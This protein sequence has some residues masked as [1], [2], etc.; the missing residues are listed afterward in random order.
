MTITS[1]YVS[2]GPAH[3]CVSLHT[4]SIPVGL[5]AFVPGQ[6]LGTPASC[7]GGSV[8]RRCREAHCG[9]S[10]LRIR[11]ANS[12][13]SPSPTGVMLREG[14]GCPTLWGVGATAQNSNSLLPCL[15]ASTPIQDKLTAL[16]IRAH[17]PMYA[18]QSS[19]PLA[20][21]VRLLH[22]SSPSR[23]TSFPAPIAV[24]VFLGP[25]SG[26]FM[27]IHPSHQR[28]VLSHTYQQ[29]RRVIA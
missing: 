2:T 13:Y 20:L 1:E 22:A 7:I 4:N 23:Q 5:R 15:P 10:T 29:V 8:C 11:L 24:R 6:R 3:V 26:R 12:H 25:A 28:S 16:E 18:P 27:A 14:W 19:T 9:P 17:L 21:P